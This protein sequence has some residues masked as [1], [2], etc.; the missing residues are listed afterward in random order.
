MSALRARS[1]AA[2]LHCAHWVSKALCVVEFSSDFSSVVQKVTVSAV[3]D[4]VEPLSIL[5]HT[6]Y[7][8][9]AHTAAVASCHCLL[10]GALSTV[11]LSKGVPAAPLDSCQQRLCV[12]LSRQQ[13]RT[14]AT[15]FL[16]AVC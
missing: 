7:A 2:A 16:V 10:R 3:H 9:V 14:F 1:L 11:Q 6:Q 5:N 8:L 12:A 4:G 13:C 15:S